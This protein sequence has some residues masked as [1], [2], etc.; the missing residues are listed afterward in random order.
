MPQIYDMEDNEELEPFE[1]NNPHNDTYWQSFKSHA[2]QWVKGVALLGAGVAGYTLLRWA[3]SNDTEQASDEQSV[4]QPNENEATALAR[5]SLAMNSDLKRSSF[6]S[7][8]LFEFSNNTITN[9]TFEQIG[10]IDEQY[11]NVLQPF[12]LAIVQDNLFYHSSNDFLKLSMT[13]EDGSP[14]PQE[15][16]FELNP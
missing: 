8:K 6:L 4:W 2:L 5:P 7:R 1:A 14:L 9:S 11:A 16:L 3:S 15:Y 10:I 12:E 13:K